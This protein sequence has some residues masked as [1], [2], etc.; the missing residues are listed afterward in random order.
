M[1]SSITITIVQRKAIDIINKYG[2][3]AGLE[4]YRGT[5]YLALTWAAVI[6]VGIA[7]LFYVQAW[8]NSRGVA[9]SRARDM[10][11]SSE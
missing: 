3:K 4:A 10:L 1:I 6:V 8:W 11:D 7:L 9:A 2:N 5:K